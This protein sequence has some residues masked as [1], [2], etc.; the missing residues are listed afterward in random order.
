MKTKTLLYLIATGLILFVFTVDLSAQINFKD[1]VGNPVL[2]YGDEGEW[3]DG[4]VW[5][6]AIIKDGDTL[7]MWYRGSQGT[8][9]NTTT[10][11]IG[12]AWSLDGIEWN[13][14][15]GNPVLSASLSWE[16]DI[17]GNPVVIKDG[18]TL[19][20]WYDSMKRGYA[21]SIDG[22]NWTKHPEPLTL[23]EGPQS[24]WD[25]GL[26]WISTIIKED[27]EYKM[28]YSGGRP[29][30]PWDNS[31]PQ[32][33]F[34]TSPDGINWTK[35]DDPTTQNAPYAFSD[36]V[37]KVGEENDWDKLRAYFPK[38]IKTD[39]GYTMF[40]TGIKGP[41]S[42]E[43]KQQTG[44]AY[45]T[46][47]IN[48]TKDE[49][50]PII[51]DDHSVV[52]WGR[53]LISGTVLRYDN[54]FHYWFCCEFTPPE[55]FR[56]Q[57][58]YAV[59]LIPCSSESYEFTT[60]AEIDSF[61]SDCNN[62]NEVEGAVTIKGEDITNLNGLSFLTSIGGSL[63][64]IENPSL[65]GLSGLENLTSVRTINIQKNPAL[66]SITG[67][68]NV[69]SSIKHLR[70][71][72][73]DALTKL[74]GLE[75][76]KTVMSVVAIIDNDALVNLKGL[77]NLD[78]IT[79]Y[80]FEGGELII[81][82][83]NALI[84]LNGLESLTFLDEGIE[85]YPSRISIENNDA[86]LS[87]QGIESIEVESV[88]VLSINNNPSLS[89]C[90]VQSICLMLADTIAEFFIE[91]NAPG[92]NSP[93][94]VIEDCDNNCL[95]GGF[96][97]YLQEDIDN[98]PSKYEGCSEIEGNVFISSSLITNLDSLYAIK[99]I[100]GNLSISGCKNLQG[101][102][103]LDNI[104]NIAGNLTIRNNENLS[105]CDAP[106]ICNYLANP[107]GEINIENNADGC[108]SMNQVL[109]SC[110]FSSITDYGI[111]ESISVNPNPFSNST[112]IEFELNQTTNIQISIYNHLSKQVELIEKKQSSGKQQVVWNA[113]GLPSGVYFCVLN[114]EGGMQTIK[115]IKMK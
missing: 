87:L 16:G 11:H 38:V 67:L 80:M 32:T 88:Q 50:N 8:L 71:I 24:E 92:C 34:A 42:S 2:T 109:D 55:S 110:D 113:E 98:F 49:H 89:V 94:E 3:D 39:T 65:T 61:K 56:P 44:L 10:G 22:V 73:N 29:D 5:S 106:G 79:S 52:E 28:W 100:G 47:G 104:T 46:D 17:V 58:G 40:Y 35:Y 84:N 30:F 59:H 74:V 97:P 21:E 20:M 68:G 57:I 77:D 26:L 114:T 4:Y 18:D 60:Q 54:K 9:L 83:N 62:C 111:I 81:E 91:N 37:L 112:T 72:D 41:V 90:D 23:T 108:E 27:N 31:Y 93:E 115:M 99:A 103:G 1:L 51:K 86:L 48:W 36:P 33:G 13:K 82:S 105:M 85:D 45:S 95:P 75:G 6:P 78:S 63:S 12:Y 7:R 43:V 76:L 14:Y 66:T 69:T 70:I 64:I 102:S 53:G 19:K 107:N 96:S 25:D 15:S 101:L